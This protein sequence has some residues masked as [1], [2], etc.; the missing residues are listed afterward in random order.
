M[1][2]PIIPSECVARRLVYLTHSITVVGGAG[3]KLRELPED[4]WKTPQLA[5]L[6]LKNNMLT[7]ISEDIVRLRTCLLLLYLPPPIN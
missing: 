5:E 4:L 2:P 1:R 3:N 6:A 7:S